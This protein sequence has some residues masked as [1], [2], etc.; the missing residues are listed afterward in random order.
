[1]Q[2]L[3]LLIS[4]TTFTLTRG[5]RYPQ[6]DAIPPM[7]E[8]WY[9]L[10]KWNEIPKA[11]QS[12]KGGFPDCD[13]GDEFCAWT[14]TG[15]MR[16]EDVRVCPD[17][18][19]WGLTYDD[20]PTEFSTAL[21]DYLDAINQKATFFIIGSRA[22]DHGHLLERA[23]KAGH[24]IASHTWSHRP[25]TSLSNEQIVAEMKW[26]EH[27]IRDRIGVTVKYMR[28]PFGDIDDRVRGILAQLGYRI[29]IWSHDSNDWMLKENVG[30]SYEWIGGNFTRWEVES[31]D[32]KTGAISLEHDLYEITVKAAI[33]VLPAL[34]RTFTV[35]P[36]ATCLND[37]H[38]YVENISYPTLEDFLRTSSVNRTSTLSPPLASTSAS[39]R[40]FPSPTPTE[41]VKTRNPTSAHKAWSGAAAK[42]EGELKRLLLWL[43][44]IQSAFFICTL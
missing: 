2:I 44:L 7:L 18:G 11:P 12:P 10:I 28:P 21:L 38:P 27:A 3:P 22:V 25:L 43:A 14:C 36:V 33:Q 16:R 35:V 41:F 9:S 20:G 4:L 34:R 23:F 17:K 42:E 29:V 5:V 39:S 30:F 24:H 37:P 15:C 1:M 8:E 26:T 19:I 32:W 40:D 31:R 6:A 13:E